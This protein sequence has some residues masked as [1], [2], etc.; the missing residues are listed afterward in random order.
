MIKSKRKGF[1]LV[2]TLVTALIG[3]FVLTGI[4]T[5]LVLSMTISNEL[6]G[7]KMSQDII[8]N[9]KKNIER[10]IRNGNTLEVEDGILTITN[11]DNSTVSYGV[12]RAGNLKKILT[13]G[14][15]VKINVGTVIFTGF[16][17]DLEGGNMR[18]T[19][20]LSTEVE[21]SEINKTLTF[22]TTTRQ[23]L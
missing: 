13:D 18:A 8:M 12:D 3:A 2:E 17:A 16:I 23:I 21:N 11:L 15:M 1:T 6:F 19:I 9:A 5:V 14:D 4:G 10:D 7:S 20:T 22:M